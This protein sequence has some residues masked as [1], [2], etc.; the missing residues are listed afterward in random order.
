MTGEGLK[1]F[2]VGN[3]IVGS[4]AT[5]TKLVLEAVVFVE[6]FSRSLRVDFAQKLAWSKIGWSFGAADEDMDEDSPVRS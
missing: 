3:G 5:A 4:S 6:T 1:G 2:L